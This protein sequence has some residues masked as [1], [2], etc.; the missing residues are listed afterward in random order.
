MA[1]SFT[2]EE[3]AFLRH[4]RFGQLPE[5]ILPEDMVEAQETEP[6]KPMMPDTFDRDWHLRH[7][8]G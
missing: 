8:A 3:H 7:S 1:E 2:D 6:D 5:R 4:V